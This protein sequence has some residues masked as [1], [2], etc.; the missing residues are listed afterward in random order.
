MSTILLASGGLDSTLSGVLAL[1]QGC[2]INPLFIDYGQLARDNELKACLNN[3]A[4]YNL[5][6]PFVVNVSDFANL[7]PSGLTHKNLDIY[8]DAFLPGRNMLFLL[9]AA[10]Y[11][12]YIRANSIVIGLLNEDLSIFP[13]QT[14]F[15]IHKAEELI[16]LMT[17]QS[18]HVLTP[19]IDF[20]KHDVIELSRIKGIY[21]AYSCHFGS[22]QPCGKCISCQEYL[23]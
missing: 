3:F 4:K 16:K 1:E 13:D 9:L 22:E 10:T 18:I 14:K 23:I 17:S 19:L 5:P 7:Y 6:K 15:F 12:C 8:Y 21:E 20:T 11:A 2:E